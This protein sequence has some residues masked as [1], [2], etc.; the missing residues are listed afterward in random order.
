MPNFRNLSYLSQLTNVYTSAEIQSLFNLFRISTNG[1]PALPQFPPLF[2]RG[3]LLKSWPHLKDSVRNMH[4]RLN[5]IT[6]R[7]PT[8]FHFQE[9]QSKNDVNYIRIYFL[10]NDFIY[11]CDSPTSDPRQLTF[12]ANSKNNVTNHQPSPSTSLGKHQLPTSTRSSSSYNNKHEILNTQP[13]H[14]NNMLVENF[15]HVGSYEYD[16]KNSRFVFA[17]N[18]F[19]YYFDDHPEQDKAP[20]APY[21][22][23]T[24]C[25][26]SKTD[27]RICPSNPDLISYHCNGDIWCVNIKTSQEV[28]LT[29]TGNRYPLAS[30]AEGSITRSP[31]SSS[32]NGIS[33]DSQDECNPDALPILVGRPSYVIREEFGRLE[34]FWWKP[35][36]DYYVVNNV[37][38]FSE[39]QLLYEETDQSNVGIV[40]IS[41]WDGT[42]EEQRYP[43]TGTQNAISHLGI[44][45][46]KVS[47]RD[48]V[49][50]DVVTYRITPDLRD[51]FPEC[52]YLVRVGWLGQEAIWCQLLNR[53]QTHLVLAIISLS[54]TFEP[55]IVHEEK[56]ESYWISAHD[57]LYFL[58]SSRVESQPLVEG[59]ELLFL[60]SSKET[61]FRHLYLFKV[62]IGSKA[63]PTKL[64]SK[65]Q[66][67]EGQWEVN[68]KD[69]WVDEEEMLV[70]FCGL[71]DTPLERQLYVLSY[72][73]CIEDR[74]HSS[75]VKT[76]VHRLTEL[77]YTQCSIAFNASCSVY[78]NI[79]SNT[80]VPPFGFVNIVVPPTKFRRDSRRLP[81]SRRL[82]LL[83]VNSFNYS[84]FET[85]HFDYLKSIGTRP[86]IMYDCQ[87]DLLPGL[88]KPELFCCKL[89]NGDLIYGSVFKPEFM[90]SGVR[91]PTVLEVYGGPEIQLVSNNFMSLR[92]PTRHLL[93][94]EGYVVVLIDC[95]GSG[96]R[97]VTF[98]AHTY[99]RMGQV[100]IADQ[101]EVLKWLA[102]NTGYIDLDR[103]AV[104]GWSYG[105]YL[106]LM[107][108]AQY[109]KVFKVAI[110]GAPVTNWLL[111]DTAYTERF[112]GM[113][114]EN[115]DGYFKGNVLNYAHLF[116]DQ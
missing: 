103:V 13:L 22:I 20:H 41:S 73:D 3:Q 16:Q 35:E 49:I 48:S 102:K 72:A 111:Y 53:S 85:S 56:S 114:N 101:I 79:Q 7:F 110:A 95:R 105:G 44:I 107:A 38:D 54:K 42:K 100:E 17:I 62:Q 106:A 99:R 77:N 46:F 51:I 10:L 90:E 91:Y 40:S 98:E 28:R 83:L 96:R 23:E 18:K 45:K 112:M 80:S 115:P 109:P 108:L 12:G 88:A 52:E 36:P 93:S 66:L 6:Q 63:S 59:S 68:E 19:I 61:G 67:T 34:G 43:K 1:L 86:S 2:S 94:S 84:F 69:L 14:P 87:A 5:D 30:R 27:L 9:W 64:I 26:Y 33:N 47:A 57:N 21:K 81:D 92:Q 37:G 65:K 55:Q 70:Y 116:P 24:E 50:H 4:R 71:R 113:P 78:V 60:W 15:A 29:S 31:C 32:P 82:A 8:N 39:H 74:R 11:Y 89:T 97:G 76:K 58:P 75:H 25:Y 104:K